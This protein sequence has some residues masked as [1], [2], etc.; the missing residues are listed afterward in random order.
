MTPP[1]TFYFSCVYYYTEIGMEVLHGK[2]TIPLPSL[3]DGLS[4]VFQNV[5]FSIFFFNSTDVT[6]CVPVE[7]LSMDI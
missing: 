5:S 4:V 2:K 3:I 6:A 1:D 7:N